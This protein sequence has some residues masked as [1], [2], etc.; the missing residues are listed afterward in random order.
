MQALEGL[1]VIDMSTV[2]AAPN[3]A[4]YLADFGA[5]VIKVEPP[6]GDGIRN[7]GW[8]DPRDGEA[9]MWKVV[10][11]NKRA[12]V[13]DLKT[14]EG[15]DVMRRLIATADVL[16]ENHRPGTMERLGLDPD[17][18]LAEHPGLVILRLTGFGQ[19]GPYA[20]RPGFATLAEAMSGFAAINGE[21][22]GPP[23][24]PPIA[25]TDEI[26]GLVGAFAVMVALRH[27]DQT[28]EGQVVD[29]SLLESMLQCMGAL[30]S[31]WGNLGY[32]QPRLRSGIPYT[33]PRG[34]Y[35]CADGV[36]VA[37]S[38]ST[39]SVAQRVLALLGH[40]GDA[41]FETFAG[42]I[43]HRA[44]LDALV[45]E[46]I[47]ARPSSE[48]LA[49]FES[50]EAAIAPVYTMADL[51]ADPHVNARDALVEVD[52]VTMQGLVA[53][54]SRT[55]GRILHAGRSLGADTEALLAE[56]GPE[57]SQSRGGLE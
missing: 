29:V 43:E 45:E 40:A 51:A 44:E 27:R 6:T 26:A 11:R 4:R 55:P 13:I 24:L 3:A 50:A 21:P 15:V 16:I 23:L 14:D 35:R 36:W 49:A 8:R 19:D 28:G 17:E 9:F 52:G 31:A 10:N 2:L 54:L 12:A 37:V 56:L 25:L 34:T 57:K 30:P 41:R 20:P 18:L 7:L 46:W 39:E 38:T 1:R 5:D 32:L 48:V 42:R 53:K 22:D 47:G 33:V